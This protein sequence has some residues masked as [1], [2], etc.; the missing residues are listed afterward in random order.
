[1]GQQMPH[2]QFNSELTWAVACPVALYI[3]SLP[4][5]GFLGELSVHSFNRE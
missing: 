2:W 4:E 5:I 1:M 3:V